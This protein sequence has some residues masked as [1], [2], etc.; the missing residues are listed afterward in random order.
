MGNQNLP[1]GRAYYTGKNAYAN[2]AFE[3]DTRRQLQTLQNLLITANASI[4]SLKTSLAARGNYIES[5]AADGSVT[6]WAS[7][8]AKNITSLVIPAGTWQ[9]FAD[10]EFEGGPIT[11]ADSLFQITTTSAAFQAVNGLS[12]NAYETSQVPPAGGVNLRAG[13]SPLRVVSVAG[14]TVFLV[15]RITFSAGTPTAG[16]A[17]R[18]WQ[19][20][21]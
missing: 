18:A 21:P 13:L 5:V 17:L 9:V 10:G 6:G 15:G 2:Q 8:V 19:V 14:V 20:A 7:N 1:G 3:L 11:G 4:A 16:G 12:Q